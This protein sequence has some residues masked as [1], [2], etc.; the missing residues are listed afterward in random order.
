MYMYDDTPDY[1]SKYAK[2]DFSH[3]SLYIQ[4]KRPSLIAGVFIKPLCLLRNAIFTLKSCRVYDPI[5]KCNY[6]LA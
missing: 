3:K 2:K 4:Y 6:T 1:I 5:R